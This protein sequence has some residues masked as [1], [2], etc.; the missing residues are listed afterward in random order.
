MLENYQNIAIAL[1]GGAVRGASHIGVLRAL[2]E[3]GIK[4]NIV[5]GSSAGSIIAVFYSAGYSP[6]EMEEIL[7][8]TKY[9]DYIKIKFPKTAFFSLE[10]LDKIFEKYI[11]VK[12]ISELQ[13]KTY[14]TIVNLKK[15]QPEYIDKGNIGLYVKASCALPVVFE[16]VYINGE[17]YIDG[18]IMD[19]L[20]VEPFLKY[21]DI[22]IIGSEVNPMPSNLKGFNIISL[23]I[24]SFYLSMRANVE[25]NKKYCDL[26]IQPPDLAKIG[27]FNT[28]KIKDAIDIG[29]FYTKKLLLEMIERKILTI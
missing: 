10:K 22:Y 26:F 9:F 14:I 24:L 11:S 20:P 5:S 17:P 15:G 2:E 18:G 4:P 16:P 25:K 3:F 1:S 19:N 23:G 12:D 29:Y 7:L 8:K 6:K 28:K 13:K 21:K 27:L